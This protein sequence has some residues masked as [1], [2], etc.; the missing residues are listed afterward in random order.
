MQ[1]H[2]KYDILAEFL[3]RIKE[4]GFALGIDKHLSLQQLLLQLPDDIESEAL[5]LTIVPLLARDAE[6]QELFYQIFAE[7]IQ[8]IAA[9]KEAFAATYNNIEEN[10][11]HSKSKT[12]RWVLAT[13]V[14]LA[15]GIAAW[16]WNEN[17]NQIN[18]DF[19]QQI[20]ASTTSSTQ[21]T[22]STSS[23][24]STIFPDIKSYP[25]P[26]HVEKH[27]YKP[28]TGTTYWLS[29]NWNW[30]RWILAAIFSL[31]LL[32]LW[33][34]LWRKRQQ[35]VA[36]QSQN[37]KPPYVWN[38]NIEG[39]NEALQ[40]DNLEKMSQL[41][42]QRSESNISRLDMPRT[43][44]H[45]VAQGGM[46]T[47]KYKK[48]TQPTDYLLLIDRQTVRNHRAKLFDHLYQSFKAQEVEIARYFYD[49]DLRVCYDEAHPH[50][51][52]LA[53]VQQKHYQ[54][55]LIVVGTGAQLLNPASGK[56]MAWTSF[57][58]QWKQRTLLSPKALKSWSY[59]ERQLSA[60]FQVLPA[61]LQSLGFW[62]EELD[63]GSDARM[64]TWR[65]K[66]HDAPYAPIAPDD[67]D[68]MP[69]L[70][71]YFEK[72]MLR[73][74]AACA[75]YPSL[76]W[77]LT[78]WLGRQLADNQTVLTTY[79]NLMQLCRLSWFV[80]GEIP[81]TARAALLTWLEKEDDGKL[82]PQLR[83]A[84]A[85][86]LERNPP[87]KDSAAFE[88]F[89][90]NVALQQWL[91]EAD[92]ARKAAL[93]NEIAELMARG[94]E[95]DFTVIK[96]L[97]QPRTA[98]DFII[99]KA[100]KKY[101]H[102]SGFAALGWLRQWKDLRWLLPIWAIAMLALFWK[103]E[104]PQ[105]EACKAEQ[106]VSLEKEGKTYQFCLEKP[107][108]SIT[109]QE[110]KLH[111]L[112]QNNNYELANRLYQDSLPNP[113]SL[114]AEAQQ[115]S[116]TLQL[117]AEYYANFALDYYRMAKAQDSLGQ[118]DFACAYLEKANNALLKYP[119]GKDEVAYLKAQIDLAREKRCKVVLPPPDTLQDTVNQVFSNGECVT[120]QHN[121]G[122]TVYIGLRSRVLSAAETKAMN[123]CYNSRKTITC[124]KIDKET[125]MGQVKN[126]EQVTF[127]TQNGNAY[128]IKTADGK[129]GYIAAAYKGQKT[130][131]KGCNTK[132]ETKSTKNNPTPSDIPP[133]GGEGASTQNAATTPSTDSQKA[134]GDLGEEK[135]SFDMVFVQGGSFM[136][137]SDEKDEY[138]QDDEKPQHK[139]TLS[140]FYIGKTEVTQKQWR[141]VMGKDP[142]KLWFK[143]CDDCPV[144]YVSWNDIQEFLQKLNAKTGKKYRLPTEAEW[145]YAAR[146]GNK[147]KGYVY[148]GSN[149]LDKVA[150]YG[151]EKADK[152]THPVGKKEANELGIF[153]M[154]GNVW[155]WCS[156]WYKGYPG[157]S[158][159]TDFTGSYRVNRGG[160]WGSYSGYCRVADRYFNTPGY[161]HLHLG[162]RVILSSE[163][164]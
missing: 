107:L 83:L 9:K 125:L 98:L 126:G 110:E 85:S 43:I 92:E 72:P 123:D 103:Y 26:D 15:L 96:Y 63:A 147:S 143:G 90:L 3:E 6:Q 142:E 160:S 114:V 89:R 82:L 60:L 67:A 16:F 19:T 65:E 35:L 113:L 156:D 32:A 154:S 152:K 8:N 88:Q 66:I 124:E 28:P 39:A 162:F 48:Q 71:L 128:Q 108:Q 76:H 25:F 155:E 145:E 132:A 159:V 31:G 137:G 23:T 127:I 135:S 46:P 130:L 44:E 161:R 150:W 131:Q 37:D 134:L 7:A 41:L 116:A 91:S 84:L 62:V 139:V 79:D 73:W 38:I 49:A 122:Q 133:S 21:S 140:D 144:E 24:S 100:W 149:D 12:W 120:V 22:D 95:P 119:K 40:N 80:K 151:Y 64:D 69:L 4:K 99:P 87:P 5:R 117:A 104:L 109:Y 146:G 55:R 50:G 34:Y 42:R 53:D 75:I 59:D 14:M 93:E 11:N 70:Q 111:Q 164:N 118:R 74:I 105:D 78:L 51:I 1:Q 13:A 148:A 61:T 54:S 58:E 17:Q 115:D 121:Q 10:I 57:L 163:N 47:F 136:M 94:A 102:P 141:A 81:D 33:R 18:K 97:E 45:T 86:E 101:V 29:N 30:L 158:G 52:S 77:D 157:S 68:P 56:V 2:S 20:E 36:Q 153:D 138:A 112:F 129:I 106:L 27:H